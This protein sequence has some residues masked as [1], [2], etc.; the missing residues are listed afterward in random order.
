MPSSTLR[1]TLNH[2]H[3]IGGHPYNWYDV[4]QSCYACIEEFTKQLTGSVPQDPQKEAKPS[5]KAPTLYST[6][7]LATNGVRPLAPI[8]PL[9]K[10]ASKPVASGLNRLEE[11]IKARALNSYPM[12]VINAVRDKISNNSLMNAAPDAAIRSVFAQGQ[13]VIW[14]VEGETLLAPF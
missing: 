8:I 4:T 11:L 1:S 9:D 2:D 10:T 5:K 3:L 7:G 13:I 14:A 6:S 12:K